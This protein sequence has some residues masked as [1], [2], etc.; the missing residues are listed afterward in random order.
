MIDDID[1]TTINCPEKISEIINYLN[2][3]ELVAAELPRNLQR[4]INRLEDVGWILIHIGESPGHNPGDSIE[5]W[6]NYMIFTYHGHQASG[7]YTYYVR[8]SGFCSRTKTSNVYQFL[9]ELINE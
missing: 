4:R 6:A 1:N 8:N 9:Y 3:L 7:V 2:S 5:F